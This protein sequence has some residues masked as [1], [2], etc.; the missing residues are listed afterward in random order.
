MM[1]ARAIADGA[2]YRL[3]GIDR[4]SLGNPLAARLLDHAFTKG[5]G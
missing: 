4:H 3:D 5:R 2:T 1:A